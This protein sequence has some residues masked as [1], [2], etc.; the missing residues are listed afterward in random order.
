MMTLFIMAHEERPLV[1]YF[2]GY[3][4]LRHFQNKFGVILPFVLRPADWHV[5]RYIPDQTA[6]ISPALRQ[7]DHLGFLLQQGV[8]SPAW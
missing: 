7:K 1:L 6:A 8:Q 4:P 2:G 3:K 5:R